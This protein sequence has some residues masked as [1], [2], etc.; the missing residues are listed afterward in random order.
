MILKIFQNG[1]LK[2]L[3]DEIIKTPNN[4][5]APGLS[6]FGNKIRVKF[7][8]SCL[9]QD[10]LTFTHGTIVNIYLVY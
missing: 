4:S 8:G 5:L 10:K 3:S 6:F 9:K 2:G 1:S 7:V